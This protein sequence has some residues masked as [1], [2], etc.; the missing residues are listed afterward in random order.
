[1]TLADAVARGLVS[2]DARGSGT[3][4]VDVS[5]KARADIDLTIPAGTFFEAKSNVQN[6]VVT[7]TATARLDRGA[8]H[9]VALATACA[10][11]HRGVPSGSDRFALA[12][13][14][15]KLVQLVTCLEGRN[16]DESR[17]QQLVWQ[18][19]DNVS[20]TDMVQH[21]SRMRPF[22]VQSCV[23]RLR[24]SVERCT[25]AVD[26]AYDVALDKWLERNRPDDGSACLR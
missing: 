21:R 12:D 22:L 8:T 19:T 5:I 17:R 2:I 14:D 15:P 24:M 20:R 6:M 7:K 18:V 26:I 9:A 13:A 23:D 10:S 16:V 11:F 4:R 25:K 3:H 1:M